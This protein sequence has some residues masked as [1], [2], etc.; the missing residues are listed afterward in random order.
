LGDC[1][2]RHSGIAFALQ[3]IPGGFDDASA[4]VVC[5]ALANQ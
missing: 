4:R 1:L 2:D 5:L 3:E